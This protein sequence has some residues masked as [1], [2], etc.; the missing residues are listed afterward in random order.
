MS[1][2]E[3]FRA[4][5]IFIIFM[6]IFPGCAMATSDLIN[7]IF[8]FQKPERFKSVNISLIVSKYI[9]IGMEKDA[10]ARKLK[11]QGLDVREEMDLKFNQCAD[12]EKLVVLAGYVK[13]NVI[14][15]FPD[16]SY[17]SV[18]LEF[19]EGR[20]AYVS[21]SHTKNVY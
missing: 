5:I 21:G 19:K 18:R 4:F 20:V 1:K 9:P 2:L 11:E 16:E 17:I 12:C 6:L 7:D 10:A 8:A 15:F 14:P 3:P 13:K